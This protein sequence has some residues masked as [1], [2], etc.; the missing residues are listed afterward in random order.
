MVIAQPPLQY[1]ITSSQAGLESFV[2]S[3]QGQI[4]NLR[5]EATEVLEKWVESETQLRAARW[6]LECRRAQDPDTIPMQHLERADFDHASQAPAFPP[7]AMPLFDRPAL[8][9]DSRTRAPIQLNG[10]PRDRPEPASAAPSEEILIEHPDVSSRAEDALTFLE[11]DLRSQGHAIDTEACNVVADAA[12][13]SLSAGPLTHS[14]A[15]ECS[16]ENLS[17]K[18]AHPTALPFSEVFPAESNGVHAGRDRVTEFGLAETVVVGQGPSPKK[19][20]PVIPIPRNVHHRP[21]FSIR[22]SSANTQLRRRVV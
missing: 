11:H 14:Q 18:S 12:D 19:P 22:A 20:S 9:A 1:L 5:R 6:I 4:A 17:S 10:S 8:S 21:L 13:K 15:D 2:L 3:R 7:R 16:T